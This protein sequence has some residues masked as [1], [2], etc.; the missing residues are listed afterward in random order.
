[1]VHLNT[2]FAP[3]TKQTTSSLMMRVEVYC[4][5]CKYFL[6]PPGETH[7]KWGKCK[8]FVRDNIENLQIYPS[9][10]YLVSGIPDTSLYYDAIVCR[11]QSHMCGINGDLHV[12]LDGFGTT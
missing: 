6:L 1:M 3:R 5:S 9:P 2:A 10:G 12:P 7:M 4:T 8:K 11:T